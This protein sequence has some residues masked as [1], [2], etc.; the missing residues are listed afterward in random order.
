M[1]RGKAGDLGG[2]GRQALVGEGLFTTSFTLDGKS[3]LLN[4]S[5]RRTGWEAG[6]EI[7]ISVARSPKATTPDVP[8]PISEQE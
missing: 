6:P 8:P 3:K 4:L 5:V 2:T 7:A 1:L